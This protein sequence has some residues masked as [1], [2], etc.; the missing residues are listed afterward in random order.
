MPALP[1]LARSLRYG[2]VRGTDT[3]GARREVAAGLADAGLRRPAARAAPALDDE[4][5]AEMRGHLDAV[6]GA[7]GLLG[8]DRGWQLRGTT[9]AVGIR[10]RWHSVLRS[11]PAGTPARAAPRA[12]PCG[13]C[14]T[15][16]AGADEAARLMGLAL[17]PGTA[18]ADAAAWIE[19]FVGG[20]AAGCCWCTTS[21]CSAW[22][23]AG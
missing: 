1:A 17:S 18:P 10:D 7:V 21:G 3:G 6:H 14:S 5:A 16:A 13:C 8:D 12:G 20:P 15:R 4:A 9:L 19:G 11:C 23:T 2:D 22:S